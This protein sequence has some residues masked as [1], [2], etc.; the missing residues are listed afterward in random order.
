MKLKLLFTIFLISAIQIYSQDYPEVT[1]KD[2]N[3]Q[4][5]SLL[6]SLGAQNTEPVPV[7]NGDT[8]IVTGVL[9]NSPYFNLNSADGA[10]LAAGAPSAFLQDTSMTEWSGILMRYPSTPVP[11]AYANLDS[12]YVVKVKGTVV[13]YFT[14]TEFDVISFEASDVIDQMPRP[15]PV[16]LTLDSLYETGTANPNYLAEKW[17]GVYVEIRNVKTS[18]PGVVG[19]GTFRIFDE[20]GTSMIVYN[21]GYYYRNSYTAPLPGTS[22]DYVRGYIETRTSGSTD[23]GWFLLDPVYP[24]DIKIGE[25]SPP[26]ISD[27][28]RNLVNVGYGEDVTITAKV[29]DA[30]GTAAV[31][32]VT[33][34]YNINGG[35]LVTVPMTTSDSIYSATIPAQNDSSIVKFYIRATD[36][37]NAE[38]TNPSNVEKNS[39]FYFVLNRDITIYDVQYSPF[40]SGYSAFN[41]YEVM[42][43]GVVTADTTDIQGD[44]SNIGP[45]VYIQDGAGPW[46]AIQVFGTDAYNLRRGE[47]VKV[48]GIVE[49][50]FGVTRIGTLDAGATIEVLSSGNPLPDP[51]VLSAADIDSKS[52]GSLIPESYEGVLVKFENLTVIDANA[53]G[54]NDGP[55]E[56][57]GGS[58]NFGEV[59]ITDTSNV[60][61]RMETQDGTH[62]YHNFWDA[63]LENAPNKISTGDTF[64]SITGILF[65]SFSNYKLDPRKDDDF[66]GHVTTGVSDSKSLPIEYN[67][68]QNYPNPFNPSTTIKYYLPKDSN[69]KLKV[70]DILGREVANLVND[71]IKAGEHTVNFNASNLASGIYIYRLSSESF[72]QAKMMMLIK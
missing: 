66:V 34:N 31:D 10:M 24:E 54:V 17:E 33:L 21:K 61:M 25:V 69:V 9:M 29:V 47:K 55:D 26:N 23:Y 5:D 16:V 64:Q 56:G 1:I 35:D 30:D 65:Y 68:S 8:V 13:E 60:T 53:D 51:V 27:V 58:R 18:D 49:E 32:S 19:S 11:D 70:Y 15:K 36:A 52:D 6:L 14:T 38:V 28:Q 50:S 2:I 45:Q 42:V 37:D 44:G 7:L 72:V 41:G 62:S 12:G 63:S 40:G 71:R 43:E 59:L 48:T 4:P 67:L 46:S 22:I 57:S 3:Y 39:Y 20:N